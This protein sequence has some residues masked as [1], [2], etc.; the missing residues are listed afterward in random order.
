MLLTNLHSMTL[1]SHY[2]QGNRGK[3]FAKY[4]NESS[5]PNAPTDV[6]PMP[7]GHIALPY[8]AAKKL[9][10]CQFLPIYDNFDVGWRPNGWSHSFQPLVFRTSLEWLRKIYYSCSFHINRGHTMSHKIEKKITQPVQSISNFTMY[11]SK[12]ISLGKP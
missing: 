2:G 10:K 8:H 11:F 4:A 9:Q 3:I 1:N 5:W 12:S 7:F 6:L